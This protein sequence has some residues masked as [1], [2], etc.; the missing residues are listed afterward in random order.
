MSRHAQD[1]GTK[2][3]TLHVLPREF[4]SSFS[5]KADLVIYMKEQL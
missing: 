1:Q 5:S 4:M 2:K 3:R